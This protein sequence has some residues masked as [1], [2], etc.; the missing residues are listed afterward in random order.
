MKLNRLI[1]TLF[2]IEH[3]K[4]IYHLN[5]YILRIVSFIYLPDWSLD[6]SDLF[7][8]VGDECA[9]APITVPLDKSKW[10]TQ[11]N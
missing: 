4:T 3:Y 6:E 7:G 1:D 8:W 5:L 9:K 11:P 2:G 10:L